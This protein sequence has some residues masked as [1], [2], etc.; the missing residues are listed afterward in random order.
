MSAEYE[1]SR[2]TGRC[3][4]SGRVLGEGEAYFAALFE[5]PEGF[6]RRDYAV[7]AWTGPPEGCFCYWRGSMPVREAKK[8]PAINHELLMQLFVQLEDAE[9]EMKQHLRFVLALLLMR[10]RL[11]KFEEAMTEEGRECWQMR[12]PGDGGVH[13]VINPRLTEEQID[14]LS[15]QLTAILTGE[16]D[17]LEA[18]DDDRDAGEADDGN[19]ASAACGSR[20]SEND[21]AS[22]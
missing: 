8:A 17:A 9:S 1:F 11:L 14:R 21:S 19:V 13:R 18:W 7:E 6:E 20:N 4:V 22:H 12:A 16:A 10:K 5:G 2:A 15:A 3:A